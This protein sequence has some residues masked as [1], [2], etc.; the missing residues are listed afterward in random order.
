MSKD[1]FVK[2]PISLSTDIRDRIKNRG[3]SISQILK[4]TINLA[5]QE[6]KYLYEISSSKD[7]SKFYLIFDKL[8]E[9]KLVDY[10]YR[11]EH[12][13][14]DFKINGLSE[15]DITLIGSFLK[16]KDVKIVK[17]LYINIAL[18]KGYYI[19][20]LDSEYQRFMSFNLES[21]R[22]HSVIKSNEDLSSIV[23]EVINLIS[24]IQFPIKH[25][26]IKK[27]ES[28]IETIKRVITKK[29]TISDSL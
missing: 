26:L 24:E 9:S 7:D 4:T 21:N 14:L 23:N 17:N 29:I 12:F 22:L 15:Y 25:P 19:V 6:P 5:L 27:I 20:N 8:D 3:F 10:L 2:F 18:D 11:I 13:N 16:I 28:N 1:N